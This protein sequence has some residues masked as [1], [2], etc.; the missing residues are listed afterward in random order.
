MTHGRL[1]NY[2]W[3]VVCTWTAILVLSAAWNTSRAWRD[4]HELALSES[5]THLSQERAF[6]LWSAELGGVY[7]P[8][9]ESVSP[10]PV[11][12]TAPDR[13]I[14]TPSGK[15]LTLVSP[16]LMLPQTDGNH[17][18]VSSVRHRLVSLKPADPRKG[19]DAWERAAL[20]AF[21]QGETEFSELVEV[22]GEPYL[23][24]M[25]P[26]TTATSCLPCHA[27]HGYQVGDI[28]GGLESRTHLGFYHESARREIAA[29]GATHAFVWL[30]GLAGI[31]VG[32]RRVSRSISER[33]QAEARRRELECRVQQAQKLESLGI[34][35][36]GVAHGFNNLLTVIL[37]NVSLTLEQL[38]PESPARRMVQKAEQATLRAA[39]LVKQ[40]LAYSGQGQY[41]V[42]LT[43]LNQIVADMTRQLEASLPEKA[44]LECNLADSLPAIDADGMHI[45]QILTNL[46]TNASEAIGDEPGV[47]TISSGTLECDCD[48]LLQTC[49][50]E[51]LPAG[52]YV[53]LEVTDTGCGMDRETLDRI[54]DPFFTTKFTGRGLGLAAV[55]GIVRGHNGA[56]ELQSEPGRGTT[57]KVL[58]PESERTAEHL[59]GETPA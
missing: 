6:N 42:E 28:R 30:L 47:I 39:N 25:Q 14:V 2:A 8:L 33:D 21:E 45:Q 9:G 11:L 40:M 50:R 26:L 57:I 55:Q 58:F 38:L 19:L 34:L 31:V 27:Q 15:Q 46:V 52:V 24:L 20:L 3:M 16:H 53:Y 29:V 17:T 5:R 54:F 10:N 44:V 36:G 1:V 41:V 7:A 43:D 18:P 23:R 4:T 49:L 12:A 59:S 56:I 32:A 13:D 22:H 51:P 48:F 37:G 35:V